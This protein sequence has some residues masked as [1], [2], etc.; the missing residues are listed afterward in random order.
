MDSFSELLLSACR[1]HILKMEA[2]CVLP[3]HYHVL[4]ATSAIEKLL[5]ELGRFHGRT[6]YYWNGEEN[7]RGR[8][9]FYRA[10]ERTMRSER[11]FYATLNYVHHNPVH[12]KYVSRW[13][14][15]PWGS[16]VQFLKTMERDEAV[17]IWKEHPI[18]EY[19]NGW[20][21]PEM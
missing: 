21:D 6:S 8:K 19:G 5:A 13:D 14:Q 18:R 10:A 20:D 15:W 12:H 11:H 3:N 1:E 7:L 17:R 9:V 2:W 16:A 4:V